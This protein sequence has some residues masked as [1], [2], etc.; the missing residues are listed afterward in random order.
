MNNIRMAAYMLL[1]KG[2]RS[3]PGHEVC[4]LDG[5]RVVF[6]ISI[7]DACYRMYLSVF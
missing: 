3:Y 1:E 2:A 6:L 4:A 5:A 7:H